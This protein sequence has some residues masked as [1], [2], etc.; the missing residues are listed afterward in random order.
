MSKIN[1]IKSLI[2]NVEIEC[3]CGEKFELLESTKGDPK[4]NKDTC[5]SCGIKYGLVM[6]PK[7]LNVP[8]AKVDD[9]FKNTHG[10]YV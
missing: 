1:L 4:L 2:I 5:P 7:K 9:F 6:A 8:A 3:D 10:S